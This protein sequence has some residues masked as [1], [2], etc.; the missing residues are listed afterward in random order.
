MPERTSG[1]VGDAESNPGTPLRSLCTIA[2]EL[3][4]LCK[5]LV[6]HNTEHMGEMAESKVWH[7]LDHNTLH[8]R[9]RGRKGQCFAV[10][11]VA[12]STPDGTT[13][14]HPHPKKPQK[15]FLLHSRTQ[16]FSGVSQALD[17]K[18]PEKASSYQ[19]WLQVYRIW[20]KRALKFCHF[21]R[22]P[23]RTYLVHMYFLS[24]S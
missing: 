18:R 14:V 1:Y 4:R 9:G 6:R 15:C 7:D 22:Q 16:I 11:L 23:F 19:F 5:N 3:P 10:R 20:L 8:R 24:E 12:V 21:K 17:Q 13:S 2:A